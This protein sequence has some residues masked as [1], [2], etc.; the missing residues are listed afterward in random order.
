MS[1]RQLPSSGTGSG[2]RGQAS[3]A[4]SHA[5]FA[6]MGLVG[7]IYVLLIAGWCAIVGTL[8]M[9]L[10]LFFVHD[11]SYYP[12]YLLAAWL[13]APGLAALF[14][15]F[16]DQPSLASWNAALRQQLAVEKTQGWQLPEWIAPPYVNPD[17]TNALIR[18]YFRAWWH[19]AWRSWLLALP[20]GLVAFACIYNAQIA[21]V[22]GW[23]SLAMPIALVLLALLLQAS[24]IALIL[25]VEYPKAHWWP[26]LKNALILSVRRIYMLPISLLALAGYGWGMTQS[27][28]LVSLLATG[29]SWYVIWASARWQANKLFVQMAQES[30]DKR[31][32]DM[33]GGKQQHSGSTLS[34]LKDVQQ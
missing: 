15:I 11:P 9:G 21:G 22:L 34:S 32:V 17:D 16:R 18:P 10:V 29:I 23:G 27:P 6:L 24:L 12:L 28:I 3:P 26:T 8:P 19:L 33:Y 7:S 14:A 20:F 31:I 30:G 2:H 5:M 25:L 13:S 4:K 1:Q